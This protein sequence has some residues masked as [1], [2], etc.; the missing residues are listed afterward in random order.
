M[1]FY[2]SFLFHRESRGAVCHRHPPREG[3]H[4]CTRTARH[5]SGLPRG[6]NRTNNPSAQPQEAHFQGSTATRGQEPPPGQ[7]PPPQSVPVD[8]AHKTGRAHE[9]A[10]FRCGLNKAHGQRQCHRRGLPCPQ[11]AWGFGGTGR[12][13]QLEAARPRRLVACVGRGGDRLA[14]TT[15]PRGTV[16]AGAPAPLPGSLDP[17]LSGPD[18]CARKPPRGSLHGEAAQPVLWPRTPP[19]LGRPCKEHASGVTSVSAESG[20]SSAPP[21]R[22]HR[23]VASAW[24]AAPPL[25]GTRL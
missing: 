9:A 23:S 22:G 11:A 10:D 8:G 15:Q 25:L 13:F 2:P 1:V 18:H 19:H 6:A 16:N 21:G 17:C 20:S 7:H 12:T 4:V 5:G 3:G 24:P 14:A